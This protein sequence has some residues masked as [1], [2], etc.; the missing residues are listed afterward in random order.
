MAI[1]PPT[2]PKSTIAWTLVIVGMGLFSVEQFGLD[3]IEGPTKSVHLDPNLLS[4][5]VIAPFI[6]II[7]GAVVFMIGRM[8]RR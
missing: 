2:K 6:L 8:R 1:T 5:L 3:K 7:A 4:I